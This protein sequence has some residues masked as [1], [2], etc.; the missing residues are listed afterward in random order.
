MCENTDLMSRRKIHLLLYIDV[1][2]KFIRKIK[3]CK[4]LNDLT[5]LLSGL[6]IVCGKWVKGDKNRRM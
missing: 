4:N 1:T 2:I 3:S 5:T 6:S